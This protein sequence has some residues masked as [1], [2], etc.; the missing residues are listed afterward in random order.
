MEFVTFKD[1][2]VQNLASDPDR[3]GED[4][5]PPAR[6]SGETGKLFYNVS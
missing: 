6:T 5:R 3:T 4:V 1:I 2:V